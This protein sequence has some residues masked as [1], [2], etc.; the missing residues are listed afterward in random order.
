MAIHL[1]FFFPYRFH[2][3]QEN[4]PDFSGTVTGLAS[5][6]ELAGAAGGVQAEGAAG[7]IS[8]L[9]RFPAGQGKEYAAWWRLLVALSVVS[10]LLRG[11]LEP[12]L[13]QS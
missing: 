9:S 7:S 3:Q 2:S 11:S 10:K 12:S 1:S 5:H 4:S 6:E 13:V 8:W